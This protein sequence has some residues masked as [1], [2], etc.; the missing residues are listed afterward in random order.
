MFMS[1]GVV[2][3]ISLASCSPMIPEVLFTV[4]NVKSHNCNT[5]FG[6]ASHLPCGDGRCLVPF[7]AEFCPR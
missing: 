3:P 7:G 2:Q 4:P 1:L 6:S 5:A